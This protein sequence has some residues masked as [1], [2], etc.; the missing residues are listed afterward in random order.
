MVNR[1]KNA[2]V[3]CRALA[4]TSRQLSN[5]TDPLQVLAQGYSAEAEMCTL[6]L[7]MCIPIGRIGRPVH[8]SIVHRHGPDNA[9]SNQP[10]AILWS[11]AVPVLTMI[12]FACVSCTCRTSLPCFD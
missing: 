6:S 9:C 12:I 8:P 4:R 7:Q 2:I 10:V 5:M 11:K 1:S 3:S